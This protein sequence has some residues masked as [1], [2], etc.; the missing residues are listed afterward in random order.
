VEAVT[1]EAVVRM[2]LPYIACAGCQSQLISHLFADVD[3][4]L[5]CLF[6]A[7]DRPA[8]SVR[9]VTADARGFLPGVEAMPPSTVGQLLDRLTEQAQ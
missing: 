2:E 4:A 3:G 8:G 5:L 6:C 9:S 7:R 1:G